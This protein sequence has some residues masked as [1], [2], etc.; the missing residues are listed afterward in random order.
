MLAELLSL[1]VYAFLLVFTRLGAALMMLPGFGELSVSTRVRLVF[2]LALTVVILPLVIDH[3]PPLPEQPVM[4]VVLLAGQI[5]IGL[6]IGMMARIRVAALQVAG[7]VI[8]YHSGTLS[9]AA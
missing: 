6:A 5:F 7:T 4:L 8:A 1:N 2:A 3:L 9:T